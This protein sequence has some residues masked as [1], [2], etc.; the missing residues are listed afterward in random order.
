M[1]AYFSWVEVKFTKPRQPWGTKS[2]K[3]QKKKHLPEKTH[4]NKKRLGDNVKFVLFYKH[5]SLFLKP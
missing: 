3:N 2:L 4:R 1:R 5:N